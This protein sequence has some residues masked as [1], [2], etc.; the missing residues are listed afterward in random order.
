MHLARSFSYPFRPGALRAWLAGLPLLLLFPVTF[1]LVLGYAVRATRDAARDPEA[2]PPTFRPDLQLLRDGFVATIGLGL[3]VLPYAYLSSAVADLLLRRMPPG[4]D[5]VLARFESIALAMALV[6]GPW[7]TLVLVLAPPAFAAFAASGRA[8]DLFD[9]IASV[10]YVRRHFA[11]WNMATVAIVTAWVVA[12]ASAGL[13]CVGFL[14]G[15]FYA[16]LVSAHATASLVEP[17]KPAGAQAPSEPQAA[18]AG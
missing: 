7:G 14:P 3:V 13:A 16:I 11:T 18:P 2:P 9:P 17:K 1:I 12:L 4:M 8:L 5:P 6:A 15:A 10:G